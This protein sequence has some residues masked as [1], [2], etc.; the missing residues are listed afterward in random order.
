MAS[1]EMARACKGHEESMRQV[2]KINKYMAHSRTEE[3]VRLLEASLQKAECDFND[4]KERLD[5]SIRLTGL[6]EA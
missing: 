4:L 5:R 3:K 1:P 6:T 2:R